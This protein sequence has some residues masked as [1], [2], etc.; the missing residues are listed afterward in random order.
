MEVTN[1]YQYFNRVRGNNI[2]LGILDKDLRND[3]DAP[4]V[5]KNSKKR[6]FRYLQNKNYLV[7]QEFGKA[8]DNWCYEEYYQKQF[9]TFPNISEDNRNLWK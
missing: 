4:R 1:F 2:A 7:S 8:F 3:P 5:T 9:Q 6:V